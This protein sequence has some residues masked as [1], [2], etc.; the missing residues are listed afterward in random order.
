MTY[1]GWSIAKRIKT[2][3]RDIKP[4][5]V[6]NPNGRSKIPEHVKAARKLNQVKFAEVLYQYINSTFAELEAALKDPKTPA[7]ELV[8]VKILAEA[9][10]NGDEKKLEFILNRT[11][12]KVIEVRKHHHTGIGQSFNLKNLTVDELK[13]LKGMVSKCDKTEE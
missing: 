9:I 10:E 7:I 12:G 4:G 6:L 3:G 1:R 13:N 11:I 2:G 5:Q 8:V